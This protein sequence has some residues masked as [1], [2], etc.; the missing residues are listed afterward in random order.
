M[1]DQQSEQDNDK[2][3]IFRCCFWIAA[4]MLL[5]LLM[6]FVAVECSIHRDG[7]RSRAKGTL[8]SI[9]SAQLAYQAGT[10]NKVYGSFQQLQDVGDI[11]SGYRLGSMIEA[12]SM[13]WEVNNIST[14]STEE[15]PTGVLSTFTIIA[16]PVD[17]GRSGLATFAIT[18]DQVVRAYRRNR[19][20]DWYNVHTWD[21]VL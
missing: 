6:A 17:R 7:W 10:T 15:L 3:G 18:E 1:S 16:Y 12:Y 14:A 9:G 19:N 8:R 5:V 13:S 11:A 2:R 4:Y 21:P 20:I